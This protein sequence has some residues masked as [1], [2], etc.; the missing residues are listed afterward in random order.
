MD[1]ETLYKARANE[2][3]LSGLDFDNMD[4]IALFYQTG[5]LTIKEYDERMDQFQLGY[6][7]EEV[8]EGFYEYIL[9]YYANLRNQ[10][11]M[12]FIGDLVLELEAGKV[13]AAMKRIISLFAGLSY[14]LEINAEKDVRNVL[15]LVFELVG[16]YSEAE[17]HT[18]DGRIDILVRTPYYVYIM[19]LKYDITAQEARDQIKRK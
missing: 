15:F 3:Q 5:Y 14:D 7:N 11:V 8:S 19:E 13:E 9:P 17:Y 4:P 6:P 2:S 12:I 10:N 18:S 1:L 16:V